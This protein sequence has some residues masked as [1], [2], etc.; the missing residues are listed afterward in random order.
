MI[1]VELKKLLEK[2]QYAFIGRHSAIKIC[3]WTKKS[4]LDEDFCYKQQFYGIKSHRCCQ[5]SPSIGFCSNKCLFCWRPIEYTEGRVISGDV[6]KPKELVKN[7]VLM[8][9]KQIEG[10]KGNSK[11]NMQKFEEAQEP[12]QFAISLAGEPTAYPKL[13]EFI[14]ELHKLGKTTFVVS[15][16][17]NPDV[18]KEINPIQ[19]YISVA[20]PNKELMKKIN[21]PELDDYWERF[22]RS[23]E[24]LREKKRG[25][26]RITLIKDWNMVEPENYAKIIE[27]AQPKFVEVKA[28]MNVGYSK[29]RFGMEH[30]PLHSDV[31]AFAASIA[32]H[33]G[34]KIIDEKKESRV[35]LLMKEDFDGRIMKF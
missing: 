4:L 27:K 26:L 30:M 1:G 21:Q 2:Q 25:T 6:D 11:V 31:R 28:Y 12:M 17:M 7:A 15:N 33:A 22:N 34:M 18:I 3:T 24:N 10:Y 32:Q 14:D 29:Q 35:V 20:A 9:R 16:G 23:L 5:M 13:K 19:L 8:Q